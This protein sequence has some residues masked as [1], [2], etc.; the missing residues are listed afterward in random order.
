MDLTSSILAVAT[1]GVKLSTTLYSYSSGVLKA[2]KDITDIA[3]DVALTSNVLN[4]VGDFMKQ[5]ASLQIA[6][7][8][9]VRDAQSIIQRCGSIFSEIENGLSK[10]MK[11]RKDGG[12]SGVSIFGKA[13]WPLKGQRVELLCRK[14]DGLKLSLM[15]LLEILSLAANDNAR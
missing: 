14:L 4:R 13:S 12:L 1:V 8:D 2:E 10:R 6:S 11:S 5:H 15:L 7:N 9:A 3:G